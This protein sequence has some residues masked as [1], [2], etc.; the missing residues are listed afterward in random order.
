M[1]WLEVKLEPAA[2]KTFLESM[3]RS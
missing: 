1:R 2:V 3:C